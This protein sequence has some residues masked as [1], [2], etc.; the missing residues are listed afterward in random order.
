MVP[1]HTIEAML[2]TVERQYDEPL[3]GLH[4]A[5]Q[6]QSA[7]FAATRQLLRGCSTWADALDA[8]VRDNSLLSDLGRLSVVRTAA[9]VEVRWECLVGS[10]LLRR[11]A[12][13]Y[14]MGTLVM[15]ARWLAPGLAFPTAVHFAHARPARPDRIRE[16]FAFFQCPVHFG[17]AHASITVP[18]A[19]LS[20]R[21]PGSDLVI[22]HLLGSPVPE[23]MGLDDFGNASFTD[24]VERLLKALILTGSP[25]K[26]AVALQL[27]TSTR[28]LHRRLQERGTSYRRLLDAQR[29]ELAREQLTGSNAP[30]TEIA[31]RLG[32]S[33]PQAFMRW[34]RQILGTT[35]SQYRRQASSQASST[36]LR[37]AG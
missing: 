7:T 25:K 11:H 18:A 29:A 32:F 12:S 27:G 35:P 16:Y 10:P 15:L 37:D 2:S 24:D 17:Q 36:R 22:H 21:L 3:F 9:K 30:I 5:P 23:S 14:A 8:L 31:E 28:S 19:L 26:E 33:T 20:T 4:M 1:L 6:I 34:F 13:E